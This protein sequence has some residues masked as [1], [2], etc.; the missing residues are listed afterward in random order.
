MVERDPAKVEHSIQRVVPLALVWKEKAM[1]TA[2]TIL[3]C[4]WAALEGRREADYFHFRWKDPMT[5]VDDE[6]LMFTIQRSIV[7]IFAALACTLVFGI[8]GLFGFVPLP[9]VFSFFHNGYYYI[10]RN[11]LNS[12]IYQ[13]GWWDQSTTTTAQVSFGPVSRTVLAAIGVAAAIAGDVCFY[14]LLL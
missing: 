3:F 11:R 13:L 14:L 12:E 4:T 6:H 5:K 9:L 1:I 2:V 8:W 10:R 7:A